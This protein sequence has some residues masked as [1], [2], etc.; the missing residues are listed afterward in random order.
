MFAV[1]WADETLEALDLSEARVVVDVGGGMHAGS[2]RRS[3][4]ATICGRP[5]VP[6]HRG[7]R[8]ARRCEIVAGDFFTNPIPEGDVHVLSNILHD[9]DDKNAAR[10]LA[11]CKSAMHGSGRLIVLDRLV[12]EGDTPDPAKGVDLNMLFLVGGRE[13]NRAEFTALA[14]EVGLRVVDMQ[15]TASPL[16]VIEMRLDQ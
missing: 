11:A 16:A 4:R 5:R 15:T 1:R 13:R 3:V 7:P 12:A 14:Q 6:P 9:W 2:A 10:I 8:I